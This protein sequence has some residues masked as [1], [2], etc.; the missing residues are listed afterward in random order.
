MEAVEITIIPGKSRDEIEALACATHGGNYQG[1][2][3]PFYFNNRVARNCILHNLTNYEEL[4][5]RT[6]R[7]RT[8][9][10]SYNILRKRVDDLIDEVYPEYR[11]IDDDG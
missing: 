10:G 3:G 11:D 9:K 5:S 6:N 4:W 1:D 7:G 2:P 8:G